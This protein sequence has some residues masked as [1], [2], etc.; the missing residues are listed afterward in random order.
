[1]TARILMEDDQQELLRQV[2]TEA[3]MDMF[4]SFGAAVRVLDLGSP[5]PHG[6][7]DIAGFIGF[8]GAVR[9]SLMISG[10]SRLFSTTYPADKGGAKLAKADVFDWTGELANQLLGRVKRL[11]CARGRDFETSTPTAIEGRE[12]GR[13]FPSRA[14]VLDLAFAVGGDV[15]SVCFEVTPPVEGKLFPEGAEPIAS[16]SEGD[17]VLF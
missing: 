7:H 13:R 16:S 3:C 15:V 14:G 6:N 9:G 10:P 8:A 5:L 2:V 1:M 17:V 11:F 4:T 12:L